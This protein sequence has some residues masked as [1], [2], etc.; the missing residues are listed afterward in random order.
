MIQN[1]L[2]YLT[3]GATLVLGALAMLPRRQRIPVR[4]TERRPDDDA[5]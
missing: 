4:V 3:L 1:L 2:T 5:R